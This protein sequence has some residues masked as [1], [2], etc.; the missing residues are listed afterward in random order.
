MTML[1]KCD[2]CGEQPIGEVSDVHEIRAFQPAKFDRLK[3]EFLWNPEQPYH[4]CKKCLLEIVT[5]TIKNA[6]EGT[7]L[8]KA[9]P[10]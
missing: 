9:T 6:S 5:D 7:W 3:I 8:T 1:I 10:Q 2:N 4:V